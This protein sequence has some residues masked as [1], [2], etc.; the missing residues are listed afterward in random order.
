MKLTAA[1]QPGYRRRMPDRP[2][3]VAFLVR[4]LGA[5]VLH[6]AQGLLARPRAPAPVAPTVLV[7]HGH[8]GSGAAFYC[9]ER[10]LEK[11]GHRGIAAFEYGVHGT[12]DGVA[13]DLARFARERLGPDPVHVVAH[14]M[15]GIIA[16]VWL[17]ELGGRAH[18]RSLVTLSSPHGGLA[19]IPGAG[20]VPLV[21][22]LTAGSPLLRRLDGTTGALADLPCLAVVS[23][24]DHF[25]RPWERAGFGAA[26]LVPVD[27]AGHV[28]VL[29]S[30]RVHRLVAE[31]LD[32]ANTVM[33]SATRR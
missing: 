28:G 6:G 25:V 11:A 24:R 22:E 10:S 8:G 17:A 9:L 33:R 1:Q 30:R 7:I 4:E 31:H 12:I 2:G 27:H 26:R 15:G 21:R 3:G 18:A 23:R 20:L 14:S 13:A 16:R 19:P 5:Y 32:A 29:Y